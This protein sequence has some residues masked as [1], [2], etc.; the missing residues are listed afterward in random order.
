MSAKI[1]LIAF[2]V[3]AVAVIY[4]ALFI[5]TTYFSRTLAFVLVLLSFSFG[6]LSNFLAIKETNKRKK[7][8]DPDK[9]D[10]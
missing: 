6:L 4:T 7:D 8:I 1:K 5:N 10:C 9:A 3:I 2:L